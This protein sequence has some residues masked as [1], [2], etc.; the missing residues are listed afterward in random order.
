MFNWR[1]A[2]R[3]VWLVLADTAP[4]FAFGLIS[5]HDFYLLRSG[6]KSCPIIGLAGRAA[7]HICGMKFF[8]GGGLGSERRLL[9][10]RNA[11]RA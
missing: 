7:V 2:T 9:L 1:R 5:P 3:Q 10:K 8:S 4:R 11:F 6:G